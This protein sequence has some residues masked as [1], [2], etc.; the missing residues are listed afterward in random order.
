MTDFE[1]RLSTR[2]TMV[3]AASPGRGRP[4]HTLLTGF[5]PELLAQSARRLRTGALLYAFVFFMN[6]PFQ[7]ILFLS[8][9]H[10]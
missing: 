4:Q 3:A 6:D 1:T 5:P 8:L 10:I 9:I 7:A 2:P